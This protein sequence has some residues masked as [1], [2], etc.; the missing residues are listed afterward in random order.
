MATTALFSFTCCVR[1]VRLPDHWSWPSQTKSDRPFG[2]R[3]S[4]GIG[5]FSPVR[6]Q[7]KQSHNSLWRN[8]IQYPCNLT[9]RPKLVFP[10]LLRLLNRTGRNAAQMI[11]GL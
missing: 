1:P 6:F 7:Q 3:L 2:H 5:L 9:L 4:L 8:V 11:F 10:C